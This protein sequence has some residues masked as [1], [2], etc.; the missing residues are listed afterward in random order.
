M[1]GRY[2]NR[3]A[4][5]AVTI[6]GVAYKI[7]TTKDGYHLHGG[8]YGF[9]KKIFK[10]NSFLLEEAV[11]ISFKYTSPHLEEGFPG[12]LQLE[13][14]YTLDDEDNWTVEYKATTSQTTIV[15]FTQHVYFNL[16]KNHNGTIHE[17]QLKINATH[18]LPVNTQQLPT[19]VLELVTNTPF[20]F[21]N[22]KKIGE[23]INENNEQLLLSSGYDHT[24]VL[25]N[26]H[27]HNL[28][29]AATLQEYTSGIQIDVHTT[30]PSIHVYTGNFLEN[31]KGKEGIIY[32]NRSGICLET[33]HFPDTPN[34]PHFP[35]TL[36]KVG[37]EFYSKTV[38]KMSSN[39]D[40][41]SLTNF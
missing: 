6:D 4:S 10:T 25:E 16:S 34:N 24:W 41:E 21:L 1:V 38:F 33:Q 37:E 8:E 5:N 12:E 31:I 36:L 27:T 17:H 32:Q 28:K 11:G 18:Y 22:F 15:N 39:I 9:N 14:I 35:T 13:V 2:A 19:G 29:H 20:N 40:S 26:T 3:I 7:S 30:E 23:H